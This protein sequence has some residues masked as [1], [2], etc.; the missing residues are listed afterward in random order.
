[1]RPCSV[2]YLMAL[3]LYVTKQNTHTLLSLKTVWHHQTKAMDCRRNTHTRL[4]ATELTFS[5]VTSGQ[6]SDLSFLPPSILPSALVLTWQGCHREHQNKGC[7]EREM[8][9]CRGG[10]QNGEQKHCL[11]SKMSYCVAEPCVGVGVKNW[12]E[13]NLGPLWCYTFS[14]PPVNGGGQKT[15]LVW[16]IPPIFL[17]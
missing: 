3:G 6:R 13:R 12:K 11:D 5:W 14:L 9:G 2:L 8:K 17:T 7:R 15:G 1:M 16:L 10:A 4:M